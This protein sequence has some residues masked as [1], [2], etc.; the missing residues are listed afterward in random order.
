MLLSELLEEM[1]KQLSSIQVPSIRDLEASDK[2]AQ[3]EK[4][5]HISL[6]SEPAQRTPIPV[7]QRVITE[8]QKKILPSPTLKERMNQV[9]KAISRKKPF[10]LG[11]LEDALGKSFATDNQLLL[12]A[13][14]TFAS[15]GEL[16]KPL[17]KRKTSVSIEENKTQML[18]FNV[19]E[20]STTKTSS[21]LLVWHEV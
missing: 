10:W 12:P 18:H 1:C 9:A 16:Y 19:V 8:N 13:N 20:S 15:T 2:T 11:R 3:P 6:I 21:K 5:Q 14:A 4:K 17:K 7:S